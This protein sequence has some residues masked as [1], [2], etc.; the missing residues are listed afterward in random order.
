MPEKVETTVDKRDSLNITD[1]SVVSNPSTPAKS[2]TPI[3]EFYSDLTEVLCNLGEGLAGAQRQLD[4][5][6]L[7]TQKEI[8]KDE[9]LSRCGF[10]ATWYVMPEAEFT[11]KMQYS[12]ASESG[13]ENGAPTRRK[14]F[15]ITPSNASNNFYKTETQE[16]STLRIKFV[17]VPSP[18]VV[19]IPKI[20]GL[21]IEEAKAVLAT[22][23]IH[24][25]FETVD[26]P[27]GNGK[28]SEVANLSVAEGEVM[29]AES[30]LTIGVK[31]G[32]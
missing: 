25:L 9:L 19:L 4:L 29:L 6:A 23:Q 32:V 22:T 15:R 1:R 30:T 27:P 21:S 3:G 12:V 28:D 18:S 26:G 31:R 8:L 16:E 13:V 2:M 20:L 11:L 10:N 7:N 5:A 24:T 17:P 14:L